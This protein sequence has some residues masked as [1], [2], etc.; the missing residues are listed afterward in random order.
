MPKARSRCPTCG[1]FTPRAGNHECGLKVVGLKDKIIELYREGYSYRSIAKALGIHEAS[2]HRLFKK[3]GVRARKPYESTK[4]C[5]LCGRITPKDGAHDCVAKIAPYRDKIVE[6]YN[7]GYSQKAIAELLGMNQATISV[8][9]RKAGI[10]PR[11]KG[12]RRRIIVIPNDERV[13]AYTAGLFDGEGWITIA[14]RKW[15]KNTIDAIQVGLANTSLPLIDWLHSMYKAGFIY[16]NKS[17]LSKRFTYTWQLTRI[18][19][20]YHFLKAV[21]PYLVI[22]KEKALEALRVAERVI[23]TLPP[24]KVS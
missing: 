2:V 16:S 11:S 10:K 22:K 7:E 12:I 1:K 20:V 23:G 3:L 24:P 13:I 6:L 21:T 8:F 19:D 5:P 9:F 18:M 4:R 17:K 15:G 14:K